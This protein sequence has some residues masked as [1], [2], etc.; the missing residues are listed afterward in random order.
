MTEPV[1]KVSNYNV[2][3]WVDGTWYPAAIDMNY[4]VMPGKTLAIV[5]ESGSGKSSSSMG[6]MGLLASNA[7]T[8]GTVE[9][10]GVDMLSASPSTVRK[11]RGK[12]VAYIFQE[13]MTAL[14]PV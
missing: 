12:E 2:D 3:F 13:P 8:S 5:G 11:F 10:K 6:L 7:R 14:N 4:E 9:V 1:L